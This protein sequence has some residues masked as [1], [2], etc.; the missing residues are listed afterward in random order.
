LRRNEAEIIRATGSYRPQTSSREVL[1]RVR[2]E[3]EE[4]E[5]EACDSTERL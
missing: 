1:T 4:E 5:E 2:K 3:E